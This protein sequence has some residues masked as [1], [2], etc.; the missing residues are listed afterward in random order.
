[1][2]IKYST[3]FIIFIP[4]SNIVATIQ[5]KKPI[6]LEDAVSKLRNAEYNPKVDGSADFH[7]I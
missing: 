7:N 5:L 4:Y 1:M 6:K 3:H 2:N